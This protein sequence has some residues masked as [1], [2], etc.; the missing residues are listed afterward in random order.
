[1][2]AKKTMQAPVFMEALDKFGPSCKVSSNRC[3][4]SPEVNSGTLD[5][6]YLT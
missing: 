3:V 6:K 5:V 4:L 2:D 1:M